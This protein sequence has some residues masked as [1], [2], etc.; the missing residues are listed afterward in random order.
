MSGKTARTHNHI[1]NRA[2]N[3]SGGD[4]KVVFKGVLD[5]PFRIPWPTVTHS[6]QNEVLAA[7]LGQ[8]TDLAD[9]HSSRKR[10]RTSAQQEARKKRKQEVKA[11]PPHRVTME[12]SGMNADDFGINEVTKRLEKQGRDQRVTLVSTSEPTN[13]PSPSP[14]RLILVCRADVNPP[15]LVDHLPHLVAAYNSLRPDEPIRLV[16]LPAGSELQLSQAIGLRRAA[17]LGF[18]SD[19]PDL[20]K[21]ILTAVPALSATWLT[22]STTTEKFIPTHIK[23]V[24]TSAPK[25]LKTEKQRRKEER[26]LKKDKQ[27]ASKKGQSVGSHDSGQK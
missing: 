6:V 5:N 24:R 12:T 20:A 3:K 23:Q 18:D 1:S 4:R 10:K 11:G 26:A 17:V 9:Y 8:F 7:A 2:R 27:L 16:P 22:S 25:D 14:L 19:C 21:D 13:V 15:I